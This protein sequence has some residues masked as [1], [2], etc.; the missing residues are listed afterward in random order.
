MKI[1]DEVAAETPHKLAER[2]VKLADVEGKVC[3]EPSA[4][5]GA[6]V[7]ALLRAGAKRIVAVELHKPFCADLR[8]LAFVDQQTNGRG[9]RQ[10]H[11]EC[12]NFLAYPSDG[13]LVDRVV[14]NPPFARSQDVAHILHAANMLVP[15]GKLVAVASAGVMFRRG[16]QYDRLRRIAKIEPLPDDSFAPETRVRTCLVT[17]G[18]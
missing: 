9:V 5:Q 4:G 11:V 17:I 2:L 15:G 3:L 8:A 18:V 7:V 16:S 10:I 6:L 13:L 12:A 14:M 1:T